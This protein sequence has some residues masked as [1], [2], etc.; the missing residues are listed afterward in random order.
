M[1][2]FDVLLVPGGSSKIMAN[3]LGCD[4]K[5]A[6]RDFVRRGGGY[7]GICAGAFLAT[8]GYPCSLDLVG[9]KPLADDIYTPKWGKV[10][11]AE[12]GT[13]FVTIELSDAGKRVLG[14]LPGL[15]DIRYTGG[16]IFSMD[17]RKGFPKYVP[18]ATYRSELTRYEPQR[19]TMIQTPAIIAAS[20][21][22]G[23]IIL[24]SPHPEASETLESLILRAVLATARPH[25]AGDGF[26]E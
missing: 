21:G 2:G 3:T 17:V 8:D 6:V 24:F 5:D 11:M 18:L 7:V 10:S 25:V 19:G 20:F 1:S 12:R 4:G 16:P 14:D 9:A 15:L 26:N 22:D 23:R 13:G